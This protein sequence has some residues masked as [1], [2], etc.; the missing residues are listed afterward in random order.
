MASVPSE[1]VARLLD[2]SIAAVIAAIEIYNKPDRDY[3]DEISVILLANAWELLLKA[4][5]LSKGV[6]ISYDED[7]DRTLGIRDSLRE[8]KPFFPHGLKYESIRSNL[9]LLID[10]RDRAIHYYNEEGISL[11][12]YNLEQACVRNY[13]DL[14]RSAFEINLRERSS[15]VLF[16]LTVDPLNLDPLPMINRSRDADENAIKASQFLYR[17]KAAVTEL[18]AGDGDIDRLITRF[19]IKLESAKKAEYADVVVAFDEN[20]PDTAVARRIDYNNWP[21]QKD[22]LEILS[23]DDS[24]AEV[25]AYSFQA[26][27]WKHRIKENCN[28][29]WKDK[30]TGT[31]RYSPRVVQMISRIS[32]ADVQKYRQEY[33]ARSRH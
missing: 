13:A 10:Y 31:V 8:S 18:E 24:S 23:Q 26:F 21:R 12:M 17:V 5:L 15:I 9:N 2:N 3:R 28:L 16:P 25:N 33:S 19:S 7:D 4:L 27:V 32:N 1:D 29:S 11:V 30:D 14:L 20:A 6:S 22:I